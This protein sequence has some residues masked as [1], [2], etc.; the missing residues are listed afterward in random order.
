MG[1]VLYETLVVIALA[2]LASAI[3]TAAHPDA[4]T[5]WAQTLL[6]AVLVL[7]IAAYFLLCWTRSG[8]TLAM[9]TWKFRVVAQNGKTLTLPQAAW[10]FA[11]AALFTLA[12]GIGF[13]WA[14]VDKDKQF[15]HDR[16]GGT[17]LV[18]VGKSST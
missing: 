4:T 17:R 18:M 6:R 12:G 9:K 7:M 8:Q 1:G 16:L 11:L 14:L 3:I 13:W 15:L 5:G 10:R 2:M